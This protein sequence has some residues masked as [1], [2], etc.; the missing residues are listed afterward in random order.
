[1]EVT[2][3]AD[4][5]TRAAIL[6]LFE[7][8]GQV[9]RLAVTAPCLRSR[10]SSWYRAACC[11]R[12][13]VPKPSWVLSD[14]ARQDRRQSERDFWRRWGHPPTQV[15]AR[16]LRPR[17]C[18]SRECDHSVGTRVILGSWPWQHFPIGLSAKPQRE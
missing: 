10:A 2:V 1:M 12:P 8:I 7:I 18:T 15:V 4:R 3:S 6:R 9:K 16:H 13:N 11:R 17:R 5:R 14:R